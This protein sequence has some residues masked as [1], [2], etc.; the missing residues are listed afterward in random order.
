MARLQPGERKT[1]VNR[2]DAAGRTGGALLFFLFLLFHLHALVGEWPQLDRVARTNGLLITASILLFIASYFLR[3]AP[4]R[5][6]VG[7]WET[8]YPFFCAVLPLVIYHGVRFLALLPPDS[9]L[10]GPASWLLGVRQSRWLTWN[11]LAM[12]LVLTGNTVTLLGIV[13]LRRSFSIMVEVRTP[14]YTGIYRFVRHPLYLGEITATIGI[15]VFRFSRLNLILT[16]LFIALQS[17]R[18]V[19]EEK[20]L[21]AAVAD[22]RE[23]RQRTGFLF[24]K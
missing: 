1:V 13:S 9:G 21:M 23:Y 15:L 16:L 6:A 10:Y 12:T 14:V 11:P 20:K 3:T 4:V 2:R 8:L 22:Y 24:P 17:F 18:A 19:I 7:L 5:P